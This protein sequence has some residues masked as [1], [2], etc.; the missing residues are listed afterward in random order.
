M[1]FYVDT[2]LKSGRI[3]VAPFIVDKKCP[4]LIIVDNVAQ[5]DKLA[6]DLSYNG[7]KGPLKDSSK[8]ELI[9][10]VEESLGKVN[11]Y[12]LKNHRP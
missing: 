9:E 11:V 7:L 1:D 4:Y 5:G 8:Y 12:R 2:D 10:T 6:K 3:Y